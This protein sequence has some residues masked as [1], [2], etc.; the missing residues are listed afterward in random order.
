MQT[1]K[2]TLLLIKILEKIVSDKDLHGLWLNTLSFLEYI[3]TRKMLKALPASCLN[4]TL[5]AHINEESR[6][7]LFFKKLSHKVSGKQFCFA[8]H[9]MICSKEAETYFQQID[10]EAT[11]FS[12]SNPILNYLYTTYTVELRAILLYSIYSK[13]LKRNEFPFTL[14]FV[15]KEEEQHLA[16]VMQSIKTLDP[17]AEQNFEEL[18]EFEHRA[19]FSLLRKLEQK[20]FHP[21]TSKAKDLSQASNSSVSFQEQHP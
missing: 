7:S 1:K 12:R 8:E 6:H 3:G 16:A 18:K 14:N 20:I 10:K 4:E 9:E 13:I 19:Y 21:S 15:L 17:F 11:S 2:T 5:L